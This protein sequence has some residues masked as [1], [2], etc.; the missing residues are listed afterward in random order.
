[1]ACNSLTIGIPK[2]CRTGMGG[3]SRFLIAEKD[4]VISASNFFI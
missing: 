4:N 3:T 2:G 1:M